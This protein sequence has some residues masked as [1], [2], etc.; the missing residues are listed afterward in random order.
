MAKL[1]PPMEK[2]RLKKIL[3]TRKAVV[4][5]RPVETEEEA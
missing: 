5:V 2:D 1:K 3:D 4:N